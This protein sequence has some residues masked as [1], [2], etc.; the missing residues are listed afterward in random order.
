MPDLV[1]HAELGN[2]VL[3]EEVFFNNASCALFEQCVGGSGLR[4]LLRFSVSAINQ[5]TGDFVE[6]DPKTRPD[7]FQYS[8]CHNH[9]HFM[10]FANY[11]LMDESGTI[12]LT[13]QKA[14]YCLEDTERFLDSPAYPCD[15]VYD[16]GSQGVSA[17][18]ADS[19]GRSLDCQWLDITDITPGNYTLHV[20]L[21]GE[22]KFQEVSFENNDLSVVVTIPALEA[23]RTT[24]SSTHDDIVSDDSNVVMANVLAIFVF[25]LAAA[26][27]F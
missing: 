15:K 9:Y 16:C 10:G 3:Y 23:E 11:E 12:V 5:G 4:R 27:W 21:N 24:P 26:A 25:A 20:R 2:D 19:Y 17:G 8:P 13:G 7:L 18:W 14:G 6:P 22:R 1:I